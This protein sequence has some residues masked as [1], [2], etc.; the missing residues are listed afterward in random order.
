MIVWRNGKSQFCLKYICSGS[1][2]F[3][4]NHQRVVW[5]KVIMLHSIE[6]RRRKHMQP[7]TLCSLIYSLTYTHYMLYFY[8]KKLSDLFMWHTLVLVGQT[9][10]PKIAIVDQ[11]CF[12]IMA[13]HGIH[14]YFWGPIEEFYKDFFSIDRGKMLQNCGKQLLPAICYAS[15]SRMWHYQSSLER[16]YLKV[17]KHWMSSVAV[18]L[19]AIFRGGV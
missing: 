5:V 6:Y 7:L 1:V 14:T 10:P 15:Y 18:I 9:L 2:L 19:R 8:H 3:T 12:I 11:P 13:L 16:T 4:K 17:F